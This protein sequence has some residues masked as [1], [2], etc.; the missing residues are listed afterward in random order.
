[1]Y[2]QKSQS[3]TED[4]GYGDGPMTEKAKMEEVLFGVIEERNELEIKNRKL[5]AQVDKLQTRLTEYRKKEL[6]WRA[7]ICESAK[8]I[9]PSLGDVLHASTG[10]SD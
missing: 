2:L 3:R 1:M 10:R 9:D 7:V 6:A 5:E 4:Q 8:I